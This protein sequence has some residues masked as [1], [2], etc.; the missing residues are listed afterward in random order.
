[1]IH[2]FLIYV[3]EVYRDGLLKEKII[4]PL[5]TL[6]FSL[7]RKREIN[8]VVAGWGHFTMNQLSKRI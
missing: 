7:S 8:N 5:M 3:F 2:Y 4:F 1:M 6:I